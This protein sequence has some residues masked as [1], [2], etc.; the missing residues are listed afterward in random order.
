MI[1]QLL[2]SQFLLSW[3]LLD[4]GLIDRAL[5]ILTNSRFMMHWV[6]NATRVINSTISDALKQSLHIYLQVLLETKQ[7]TATHIYNILFPFCCFLLSNNY[8]FC[9]S[10]LIAY[11]KQFVEE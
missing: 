4:V 9:F 5:C 6:L 2:V 11:G 8:I 1:H 10:C 7:L 3:P